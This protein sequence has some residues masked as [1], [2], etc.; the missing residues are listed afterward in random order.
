[1]I[2]HINKLQISKIKINSEFDFDSKNKTVTL[3]SEGI[4]L[5]LKDLNVVRELSQIDSIK[6]IREVNYKIT[7]ILNIDDS[8]TVAWKYLV[9]KEKCIE[10]T[11][12]LKKEIDF[13]KGI[14]TDYHKSV[15][16]DRKSLYS[17]LSEILGPKK[18]PLDVPKYNHASISGRT[19]IK[20][21]YNFLS[22][23]KDFRKNCISKNPDNLLVS[24]DFKACEPNLYLRAIGKKINQPDVYEYLVKELDIRVE[25]RETLKRG[26]L[27]VLYG[28]SDDTAKR[29]LGGEKNTLEKIKQFFEI[30]KWS[31]YLQNQFDK[32]QFIF[33]MYGRP[34]VSDKSI[35]NKWIQS[36]AVDFCSLAFLNLVKTNNLKVAYLVHD[37]MV[38]DC[39]K[40]DFEKIKNIKELLEPRI[41]IKLPVEVT[42]LGE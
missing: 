21:G 41:N 22:S 5:S 25:K 35:L 2:T 40:S 3:G 34:I 30:E 36:S 4:S 7:D 27:S 24:I 1:M 32:N 19:S 9:G 15:L 42:V 23:S 10:Y 12:Y 6:T 8:D 16:R 33:N 20:S 28:A 29:I 26:I 11:K 37:D 31:S 17:N 13:T 14:L 18:E 38:L 39:S